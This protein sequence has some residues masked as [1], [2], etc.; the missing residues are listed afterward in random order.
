MSVKILLTRKFIE[1]PNFT[2][3]NALKKDLVEI[4]EKIHRMKDVT[5][6][7]LAG[8]EQEEERLVAELQVFEQK[9]SE[10]NKPNLFPKIKKPTKS[11][12]DDGQK[13]A[14][15]QTEK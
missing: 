15:V 10:W 12:C 14:K 8:L 4:Q 2:D 9:M 3:P 1:L 6:T 7:S 13:V 11:S 5:K